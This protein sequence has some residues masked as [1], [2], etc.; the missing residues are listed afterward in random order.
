MLKYLFDT[1]KSSV[2]KFTNLCRP[3]ISMIK[4]CSSETDFI[5]LINNEKKF[6]FPIIKQWV[7]TKNFLINI[8]KKF[9]LNYENKIMIDNYLNIINHYFCTFCL[10]IQKKFYKYKINMKSYCIKF[11]QYRRTC[12]RTYKYLY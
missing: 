8:I 5:M 6:I 2:H 9:Q 4:I 3:A 1:I 12:E 10:H 11:I 7:E